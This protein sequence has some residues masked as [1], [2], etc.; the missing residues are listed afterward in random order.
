MPMTDDQDTN[1]EDIGGHGAPPTGL[2]RSQQLG[3]A[4][5]L[6]VVALLGLTTG[7]GLS[8]GDAK[9]AVQQR[10][11]GD[12][13]PQIDR[14]V[15]VAS[16]ASERARVEV[17]VAP[18]D[19]GPGQCIVIRTDWLGRTSDGSTGLG[20]QRVRCWFDGPIVDWHAPEFRIVR[21]SD[22]F[23][24]LVEAPIG[25][26]GVDGRSVALV[27]VVYEDVESITADFGDGAQ[28]TFRIVT[29]DGW[30]AV[31]LPDAIADIDQFTGMLVN[32]LVSLKLVDR[33]GR[34]LATIAPVPDGR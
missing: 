10:L 17:L 8:L 19:R 12:P 28:Y 11:Y 21:P 25:L 5:A 18:T 2:R 1:R 9:E 7:A 20:D 26:V 15:V 3:I 29:D 4:I 32:E 34:V 33:E 6:I 14:A 13:E 22:R 24:L 30:F 27:G 31:I 23:G 16:D